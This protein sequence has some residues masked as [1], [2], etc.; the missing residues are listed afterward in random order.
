ME[1][2]DQSTD[3][4]KKTAFYAWRRQYCDQILFA[5][6]L[7]P[8]E[9]RLGRAVAKATNWKTRSTITNLSTFAQHLGEKVQRLRRVEQRLIEAGRL[10]VER[11]GALTVRSPVNLGDGKTRSSTGTKRFYRQRG[12]VD[13]V[14]IDDKYL[15]AAECVVQLGIAALIDD[16]TGECDCGQAALAECLSLGERTVRNAIR[17]LEARGYLSIMTD[18]GREQRQK[19][20]ALAAKQSN[21]GTHPG[22][23]PG[24]DPGISQPSP[25]AGST[26]WRGDSG[27]TED[28]VDPL[29]RPSVYA[30]CAERSV[31]AVFDDV[32]EIIDNYGRSG[33]M[34]VAGII[35]LADQCSMRGSSYSDLHA[36]FCAGLLRRVEVSGAPDPAGKYAELTDL[37]RERH[38]A[39]Q[40]EEAA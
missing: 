16:K 26:A 12:I 19:V 9:K 24:N 3:E 34:S 15:T 4:Q 8:L 10:K 21:P 38:D 40:Q 22:S 23:H 1:Y 20:I 33:R 17:T 5:T 30:R 18:E 36:L 39:E 28:A 37:A 6:D 35:K 32:F 7:K 11:R 13:D 27:D 31:E 29:R 2:N 14:A 25:R